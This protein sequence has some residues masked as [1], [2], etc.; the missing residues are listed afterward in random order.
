MKKPEEIDI[1]PLLPKD[2]AEKFKFKTDIPGPVFVQRDDKGKLLFDF[3]VRTLTL[4]ECEDLIKAKFPYIERIEP[5]A[6]KAAKS[7]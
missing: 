5:K 3:D 6:A 7:E 2:V 4:D 1:N